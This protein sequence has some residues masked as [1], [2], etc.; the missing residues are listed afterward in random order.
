[1]ISRQR[2]A[3]GIAILVILATIVL[4]IDVLWRL[5][6]RP[7]THD[8]FVLAD[9]AD[10]APDVSGRI[11]AL[12]V[13]DNQR[14]RKGDRLVEIDPEPFVLKVRQAQ[15]QVAALRAQIDLTARQ[16]AAQTSGANA[17]ASQV[18]R[19]GAQLALA[20]DTRARLEPMVEKGFVTEQQIDEART[21]ERSAQIALET[22]IQQSTQARQA[23]TDAESLIAQEHGAEALLALAERDRRNA[24]LTAPFDGLVVGL[25]IAEGE[26]AAAGHALFTVIKT[27]TWYVVGNFR[28]TELRQIH[29]GDSAT[30]WIMADNHRPLSGRVDSLGWGVRPDDSGV[31]G[32]PAVART[33]SWVIVAQRFP[34]RVKLIDPPQDLMRIGATAD[35]TV[36]P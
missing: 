13:R 14:V 3:S 33:L 10:L 9:T 31:P 16:I 17:A 25:Q 29:I 28:E 32:L 20:R 15:A 2:L 1:M 12:T 22:A 21:N 4:G 8:A 27:D 11:I 35:V 7:R 30:A 36:R 18:G 5:D 24:T 34:V 23:I 19:A 6:K 26:Y